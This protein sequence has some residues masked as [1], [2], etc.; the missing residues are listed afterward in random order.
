MGMD[1]MGELEED[2][3][4]Y[5]SMKR[6]RIET[7][8]DSSVSTTLSMS[9]SSRSARSSRSSSLNLQSANINNHSKM[10]ANARRSRKRKFNDVFMGEIDEEK[11]EREEEDDEDDDLQSDKESALS[12]KSRSQRRPKRRRLDTPTVAGRLYL[13]PITAHAKHCP[14]VA[15]SVYV[16]GGVREAGYRYALRLLPRDIAYIRQLAEQN[17]RAGHGQGQA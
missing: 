1:S 2:T 5:P 13:D 15:Q 3:A 11:A 12:G 9:S 6:R 16:R 4:R 14:F 17:K 8:R 10:G 7:Q